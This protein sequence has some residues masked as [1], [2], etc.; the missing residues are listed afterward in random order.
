MRPLKLVMSAFGP[1][2]GRTELDMEALGRGGLYLI[3]GDTG[4]GKT[5]VFDAIAFALYGEVSG[6]YREPSMLR[7]QYASADVPTE[8]TLTFAYGEKIYTVQRSPEYERPARRGGGMTRQRAEATL[9][10]PDGAV[11][12]RQQDVNAAIRDILGLDRGQFLQIAM[13]AQGDFMRLL[14][15]TTEERKKI[16]RK[17]FKTERYAELQERLKA[18]SGKLHD[19]CDTARAS[20]RQYLSGVRCEE[21]ETLAEAI[22]QSIAA[23]EP[24]GDTTELLHAVIAQD[25]T[26]AA[27]A[28]KELETCDRALHELKLRLELAE[29]GETLRQKLAELRR[30]RAELET[31]SDALAVRLAA[32]REKEPVRA[33]LDRAIVEI[34]NMLPRYREL[35]A[36]CAQ[37]SVLAAQI[38]TEESAQKKRAAQLETMQAQLHAMRAEQEKIADAD[39]VCEK[40]RLALTQAAARWTELE[41]LSLAVARRDTLVAQLAERQTEY[42]RAAAQADR[43]KEHYAALSRAFLDEQAGVLAAR[44]LPGVPC[45]VCGAIEHP[46]PAALSEGAPTEAQLNRA[47]D[48]ASAADQ[49]AHVASDACAGLRGTLA[50]EETALAE[51]A[52]MLLTCTTEE[53]P[54][55]LAETMKEARAAQSA[56]SAQ[57]SAEEKH[58]A[59]R[60]LLAKQIPQT[61]QESEELRTV[62]AH[63]GEEIAVHS[64]QIETVRAQ[65]GTLRASL[66]ASSAAE[67]EKECA[68]RRKE[69]EKLRTDL[70]EAEK[71]CAQC[72]VDLAALR[73]TEQSIAAQAAETEGV[74]TAQL[75]TEYAALCAQRDSLRKTRENLCVRQST[76]RAAEENIARTL[77]QLR[78]AESAWNGVRA[79]SNTA[80][81]NVGGREKLMLETYVQTAYLDRILSRANLRLLRMSEG[82]YELSRVRTAE[83]NKS[84]SGLELEVIDHYSGGRR[85]VKTLSG[86]E[87]FEAS[88]ALALGMSDEIQST[89][90]GVRLDSMFIDEG[91][92]SLDEEALSHA[93]ETLSMLG[94]GGRLVGVISHV[95]E[96]KTRID[97]QIVVTA[98]RS[99]GSRA[100]VRV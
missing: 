66:P 47:K 62:I 46:A 34:E 79:L 75:R 99:G 53:I 50:A 39:A 76:N 19:S 28:E 96:L 56:L 86:G 58:S 6:S 10:L 100:E 87:S 23:G 1:Y 94:D 48:E 90:G 33:A 85:S 36:L 98:Q 78:A 16:F 51:R 65:I 80:S 43:A 83:N 82:R 37:E 97:R 15:S 72:A 49:R 81:G 38:T 21:N 4:A 71:S 74:D 42:L 14:L 44:L 55:H 3:T 5:T 88:L 61:E 89:A 91:F 59:R 32:E 69:R 40:L 92:G 7:S 9:T 35:D 45:P 31:R 68:A 8:V 93:I 11:I 77:T 22:R 29:K 20:L 54:A 64:A 63:T 2:A 27:A 18:E 57:L 30:D 73:A 84:Q 67:A 24:I 95:G 41:N 12:T 25:E 13:I 17:L 52:V 26:S 70:A 60:R